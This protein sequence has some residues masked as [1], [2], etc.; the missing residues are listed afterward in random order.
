[1]NIIGWLANNHQRKTLLHHVFGDIGCKDVSPGCQNR[2][3]TAL[4]M[5]RSNDIHLEGSIFVSSKKP[6]DDTIV[7]AVS[8]SKLFQPIR[9]KKVSTTIFAKPNKMCGSIILKQNIRRVIWPPLSMVRQWNLNDVLQ[10]NML[11][12]NRRILFHMK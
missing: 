4:P 12:L 10:G 8:S 11:T 7:N 3:W 1:M 2:P 6:H 5:D 9:K